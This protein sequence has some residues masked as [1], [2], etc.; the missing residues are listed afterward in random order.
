MTSAD[1]VKFSDALFNVLVDQTP[2][3]TKADIVKLA[4][5]EPT[6]CK[7]GAQ[8]STYCI[9]TVSSQHVYAYFNSNE[10]YAGYS[11]TAK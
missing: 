6:Q 8:N 4:G 3:V 2:R 9:W 10:Q 11:S 7:S 1:L 5:F